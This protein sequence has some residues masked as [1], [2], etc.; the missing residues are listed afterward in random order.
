MTDRPGDSAVGLR[1]RKKQRTRATIVDVAARLCVDQGFDA[2]TVEQI[3]AGADVSPRTFSRYFPNKEAVIWAMVEDVGELIAEAVGRQP[4]DITEHEAMVRA[5][6]EVFRA[7][8]RDSPDTA[9]LDRVRGMLLIINGSA[10]L[11][12][13][14][15]ELRPAGATRA[16]IPAM[17]PPKRVPV[18][19]PAI[20]VLF[21]TWAVL[22]A[23]ALGDPGT[24][25][26]GPEAISDRI[27]SAYAVFA[28][29]WQPWHPT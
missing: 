28:R 4:A 10:S 26:G 15:V 1:E 22:M 8:E 13:A 23:S 20:R 3:A 27:E 25:V 9:S 18:T 12:L 17:A 7:A 16:V 24:D 5:H 6:L 19:H 11:G 2:T 21:D 14:A 29:L